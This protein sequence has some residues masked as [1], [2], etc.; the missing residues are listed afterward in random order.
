M[1]NPALRAAAVC[2]LLLLGLAVQVPA[3]SGGSTAQADLDQLVQ[4]AQNIVRGQ[5]VSARIEPH[6]Q[7]PNL[8]TVL[9]T[10]SVSKVLKGTA[11]PTL[12]F[13]QFVWDAREGSA[14]AAY[15]GAG[16]MILFLNPVSQYGLTS[17]VGLEQGRFRVM[18]DEKGGRFVVNGRG[19]F[20]LF[21]QVSEK[22]AER[23]V[24]LS[25]PTLQMLAGATG[26]A[27]LEAFEQAVQSLAG[28]SK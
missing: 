4:T 1:P 20:G 25:K 24:T 18:R 11:G 28:A 10:V 2:L 27:S 6:P 7:F 16:E 23:G 21:N 22:A 8:K 15:K 19:N 3:Q 9:I 12:T 26:K 17:P 13:R 5:V 14:L